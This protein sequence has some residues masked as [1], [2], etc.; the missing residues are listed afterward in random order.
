MEDWIKIVV[1]KHEWK[2]NKKFIE[3]FV[4]FRIIS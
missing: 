4:Y 3:N 1:S 2:K